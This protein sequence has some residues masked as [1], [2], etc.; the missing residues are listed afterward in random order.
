MK[1]RTSDGLGNASGA[2]ASCSVGMGMGLLVSAT[3]LDW[4]RSAPADKQYNRQQH[5]RPKYL[6][7]G[8]HHWCRGSQDLWP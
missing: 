3:V 8:T 1:L 7:L 6:T 4:A 2:T 5:I